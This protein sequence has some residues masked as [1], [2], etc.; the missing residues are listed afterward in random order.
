MDADELANRVAQEMLASEGTGPSWGIVIEEARAGYV[1]LR[2]VLREDMLN[3]HRI[4]HG[5]MVFSLADTA[6]A[7]VCNGNNERTVA[8][9]A[10]IVFLDAAKEGETLIAEGEEMSRVGRG[11]VTRVHVRTADGRPIAEFTGYSRTIGGPIMEADT[12][13]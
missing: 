7:Y 1:R 6:F 12:E 5:G 10:S 8:A 3:G 4:A 11:G 13:S 2:M 9:Q